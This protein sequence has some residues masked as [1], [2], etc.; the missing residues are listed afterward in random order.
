MLIF[1]SELVIIL[2]QEPSNSEPITGGKKTK[3]HNNEPE[4]IRLCP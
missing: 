4:K 2:K 3:G 1:F